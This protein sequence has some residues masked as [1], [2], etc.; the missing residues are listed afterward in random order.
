MLPVVKIYQ[1]SENMRNIE[2][3]GR[4]VRKGD[5]REVKTR[6]GQ[7]KV[8]WA[9]LKDKTGLIRLN[10]WRHQI[11]EVEVGDTVRLIN[12]FEKIYNGEM[13]LNIGSDGRIEVLERGPLWK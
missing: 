9:I 12:A 8:S 11:A 5:T 6:Y 10:L 7:A 13:E 2:V 4:I 3:T 1:I